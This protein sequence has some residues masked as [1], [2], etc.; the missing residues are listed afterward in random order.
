M[1]SIHL[2]V[3]NL[4]IL[5]IFQSFSLLYLLWWFAVSDLFCNY[6]LC[7]G[8][9]TNHADM[10]LQTQLI[11]I[12]CCDCY[13]DQPF[14]SSFFLSLKLCISWDTKLGKLI[15]LQWPLNV[16]AMEE[17]Y[18]SHLKKLVSFL[19]RACRWGGRWAFC[20]KQLPCY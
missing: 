11:N 7:F 1:C 4:A 13:I 3:S 12:V 20:G 14:P 6:C 16:Q 9:A 19:R 15:T 8:G 17:S 5:T 10:S 18:V 2:S